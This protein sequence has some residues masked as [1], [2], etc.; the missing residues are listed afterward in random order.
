MSH[1]ICM[2]RPVSILTLFNRPVNYKIC[3]A[4]IQR[5]D[6]I[7][8]LI[9][10][11]ST[12]VP[13]TSSVVKI[14]NTNERTQSFA[15]NFFLWMKKNTLTTY[16]ETIKQLKER[17][18]VHL[19]SIIWCWAAWV[20]ALKCYNLSNS[21]NSRWSGSRI[22]LRLFIKIFA[23]FLC[24]KNLNK[25]VHTI[26]VAREPLKFTNKTGFFSNFTDLAYLYRYHNANAHYLFLAMYFYSFYS[27]HF[28]NQI[29]QSAIPLYVSML[30]QNHK[31]FIIYNAKWNQFKLTSACVVVWT[32]A[33]VV[34]RIAIIAITAILSKTNELIWIIFAFV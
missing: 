8:L 31:T 26:N 2:R 3:L 34:W 12:S 23:H 25:L 11:L 21:W 28:N 4:Q 15:G 7:G 13:F 32:G 14:N 6:S 20:I 10:L 17:R 22:W 24:V 30:N 19:F 27:D 33:P 16:I 9:P 29:H 5:C 18:C 1:N